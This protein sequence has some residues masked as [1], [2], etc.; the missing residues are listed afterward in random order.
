MAEDKSKNKLNQKIKAVLNAVEYLSKCN[1]CGGTGKDIYGTCGN[2]FKEC[3][4]PDCT[5]HGRSNCKK[6]D[7][8]L[9]KPE[10]NRLLRL[11]KEL[12]ELK[13]ITC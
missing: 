6:C 4:N 12:N 3:G 5:G 8:K 10:F 11:T 13:E 7:G 2:Y 1:L 9:I